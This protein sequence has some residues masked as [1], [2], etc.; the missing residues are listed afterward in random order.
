MRRVHG[1]LG[2]SSLWCTREGEVW[3]EWFPKALPTH[4][5]LPPEIRHGQSPS[6]AADVYL[7]GALAYELLTGLS[8]SR[9]WAKAPLVELS[10]VAS[11]AYFNPNV[12]KAVDA[13]VAAALSRDPA[14][15]PAS[16]GHVVLALEPFVAG[17]W[18][19]ALCTRVV[20]PSLVG[21]TT[22]LPV[23]CE[24]ASVAVPPPLPPRG[25]RELPALASAPQQP[26]GDPTERAESFVPP[27]RHLALAVALAA[28]G[29]LGLCWAGAEVLE[30]NRPGLAASELVV[31]P[32]P[33]RVQME[34][35]ELE[36]PIVV[37]PPKVQ[38]PAVQAPV[39]KS[40]PKLQRPARPSLVVKRRR[41]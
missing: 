10:N 19:A 28:L 15:R 26:P 1:G 33:V 20:S 21:V 11:P 18:E 39:V 29:T 25:L 6:Y 31:A 12:P 32:P 5:S 41:G 17:D 8:V 23:T 7:L 16:M 3:L 2:P 37:S 34:L 35:P 30:L 27:T 13:L 4:R 22:S 40:R 38:P 14:S 36:I 24:K 9:A